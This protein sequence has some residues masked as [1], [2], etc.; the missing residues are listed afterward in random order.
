ML[1][2]TD[3]RIKVM[4]LKGAEMKVGIVGAGQ[5]GSACLLSLVMRGSASE[6]VLINRDQMK[7]HG[8]VTDVRYGA[9]LLPRVADGD[10]P[11]R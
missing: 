11:A 3:E 5:V 4:L 7:A 6:I 2:Q 1:R 8:V 10:D 9:A